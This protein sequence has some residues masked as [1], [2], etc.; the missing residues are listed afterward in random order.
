[1][2]KI[3]E[4]SF[5]D[6]FI[7]KVLLTFYVATYCIDGVVKSIVGYNSRDF[8]TPKRAFDLPILTQNSLLP[9]LAAF[10]L[11]LYWLYCWLIAF[12]DGIW[13]MVMQIFVTASKCTCI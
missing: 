6:G 10:F 4:C 3:T 11:L 2:M 1:M 13:G 7:A 9:I 8:I 5:L 12:S